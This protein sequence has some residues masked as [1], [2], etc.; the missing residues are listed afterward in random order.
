MNFLLS[1]AYRLISQPVSVFYP[2]FSSSVTLC[3]PARV[4]KYCS[5][6]SGH[7]GDICFGSM[8]EDE[9][10][11]FYLC[12]QFAILIGVTIIFSSVYLQYK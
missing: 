12:L 5:S 7:A 6:E 3:I 9:S 1:S 2:F 4:S 8:E 11:L 10:E